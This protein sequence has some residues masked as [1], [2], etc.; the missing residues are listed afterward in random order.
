MI[1]PNT[2]PPV[3]ARKFY[4]DDAAEWAILHA[5]GWSYR[6]LATEWGV[7]AATICQVLRGKYLGRVEPRPAEALKSRQEPV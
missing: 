2:P 4:A 6:Q 3:R 5:R 1:D 7:S